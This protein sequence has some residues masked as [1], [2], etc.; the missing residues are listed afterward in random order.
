MF[1]GDLSA[2]QYSYLLGKSVLKNSSISDP[3]NTQHLNPHLTFLQD[4][5]RHITVIHN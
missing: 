1:H 5:R 2:E 3:K 4:E